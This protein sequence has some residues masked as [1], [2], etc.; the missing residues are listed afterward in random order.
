MNG[1]YPLRAALA[2]SRGWARETLW[3]LAHKLTGSSYVHYYARRMDSI[4]ARNPDW[5]LGMDR[6][7][8]LDYLR[9]HGLAPSSTLLDFGCGALAAG[10][11]FIGYL[12]AGNYFGVDI[13]ANALA[14]GRRRVQRHGLEAKR[15]TLAHVTSTRFE[16]FAGREFDFLWAQSVFTHMPPPDIVSA[17][18]TLRAHMRP[19]SVFF[20]TFGEA[21]GDSGQRNY[22]DWYY[23]AGDFVPWATAAGLEVEQ[24]QDWRHPADAD[25]R[26]RM[27][28]FRVAR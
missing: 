21:R 7:F 28:R 15:P 8:Q 18:R 4:V 16:H 13:S 1:K 2:R 27:L 23:R 14:E 19:A 24:M 22:K 26:D 12:D 9:A 20:A 10:V 5:G 17:L 3:Y 6:S 11:L 25:G